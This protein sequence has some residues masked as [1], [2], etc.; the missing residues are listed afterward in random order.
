MSHEATG[1]SKTA[2]VCCLAV[3]A[4]LA[5]LCSSVEAQQPRGVPRIGLVPSAGNAN[6]PGHEVRAFRQGLR[7]LGYIEGKNILIEYRYV[8]G[9]PEQIPA[10]IGELTKLKVDVIV[11]GSPGG[12]QAAKS[13]TK[14]IP[15]VFVITQDPV[16]AG[17]VDSLARPGGNIT[18]ITRLT[19]DLSGKRLELLKE[20]VPTVSRVGVIWSGTGTGYKG[21]VAA[22]GR[23]KLSLQS[24]E[25]RLPNPDFEAIFRAAKASRVNALVTVSNIRITVYRKEIAELAMKHHLPAMYES[26]RWIE[27]GGLMSYGASDHE[28]FERAAVYVDKILKGTKPVELPVEQ[29]TKFELVVNLKTAKQIRLTIPPNLLARAD[30]VLR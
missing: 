10:V 23:M 2:K 19:R 7:D 17:Y 18:G 6:N 9:K 20:A 8:E 15:I 26:T 3:C 1:N 27:A 16:A 11:V 25:V 4:L 29:P 30:R 22:A 24:L 5:A 12:V 28:S 21:Y 14:T 13:N